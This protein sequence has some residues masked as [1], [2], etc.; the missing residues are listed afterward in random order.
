MA[1]YGQL[2]IDAGGGVVDHGKQS[3]RQDGATVIIGLGGTGT[4]AVI[5][6]KKEIYK[7]LKPDDEN[8]IIPR[9][10]SIRF[11]VVD[12]DVSKLK[13]QNGNQW[14][15]DVNTEF[16]DISNDSIKTVFAAKKV[17]AERKYLD[18][19]DYERISPDDASNGAGGIRQ[20]GRYL[21]FDKAEQLYAKIKSQ[22]LSALTSAKT[23]K[24]NVHICAGISGG[25]GSGTFID[26]CYLV[27]R[28]LEELG[29]ANSQ[30]CG[31]FFLPDVNLSVPS[32][33]ADPLIS[34]YIKVNGY[35]ALQ[36]LDY[37][38]NMGNNKDSF[39]ARYGFTELD[40]NTKPV[41]LCYLVS[42]TD[43]SGKVLDNGYDYAMGVVSDFIINFLARVNLPDGVEQGKDQGLTLEG[44]I[45]NL[46]QMKDGIKL[47]YGASVDYNILGAA[48]AVMPLSEIATYLGSQLFECYQGLYDRAPFEKER[49]EFLFKSQ[50]Q[51]EDIRGV[52][53]KGCAPQ[54]TFGN[55]FDADMYIKMGNKRFIERADEFFNVN[56][57]VL[58]KNA[59]AMAEKLGDFD[60]SQTG[61]SLISRTFKNLYDHYVTN[62][63]FGPFYAKRMIF[64]NNNPNLVHAVDGMIAQNRENTES[65]LRQDPLRKQDLEEAKDRMDGAGMLNKGKRIEEYKAALNNWYVHLYRLEVYN[66][67]DEILQTYRRQ[68]SEL[69][70][71]F[72]NVLT[73]VLDTLRNTFAENA[74]VLSEG[75]RDDNTYTWK[76]LSISDIRAGLDEVIKKTDISQTLYNL[77]ETMFS[78]YKKW[79][80]EDT[81]EITKLISDFIIGQ[82]KEATRKTMTDYLKERFTVDNSALLVSEIKKNII[83]DKLWDKST[84]LFWRN[85]M[86]KSDLGLKTTLTV[87]YD[88]AEIKQAAY[89]FIDG[90]GEVTVRE[91]GIT[92]RLS[93]M[94]FY[95]GLPMY[96]YQGIQELERAYENDHKPG[97]HLYEA[98][99]INWNEMLPSPIPASF[100]IT[101]RSERISKKNERL[102][103]ELEEAKS[104]G[105]V[106]KD[107]LNRTNILITDEVDIDELF[108]ELESI[109]DSKP[110]EIQAFVKKVQD[111]ENS[112]KKVQ[113][114]EEIVIKNYVDDAQET[115]VKD[116]YLL[117]PVLNRMVQNELYKKKKISEIIDLSNARLANGSADT[118]EKQDFFNAIYT[119]IISYGNKIIY[120][121]DEYAKPMELQNSSM[122]FGDTG[123]YCAFRTYK[124]LDDSV[125]KKIV[126]A[127]K[128]RMDEDNSPEVR[129]NIEML[130]SSL[131]KRI[132]GYL[133][134]YEGQLQ[135]DEL[136][137]FYTD[138]MKQYEAFK[139]LH[140]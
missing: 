115:F 117:S 6:L 72:F 66:T 85:S 89:G 21:L 107:E 87:P 56:K 118:K 52:L 112:L 18:W 84:P 62:M 15:I 78:N 123:V 116:F 80:T 12:S 60:I 32:V 25:T 120:S 13:T 110:T 132:A 48:I 93:M 26:V 129:A 108:K 55:Q 103:K 36:E 44:H 88:A 119:G 77:M 100:E 41:D 136:E 96:A 139:L 9:Y 19:L 104:L 57:G 54:V 29:K 65:E 68:L 31:F 91:S 94:R 75:I 71:S 125:K 59:T 121:F 49:D 42:T 46:K 81:N 126:S 30:V 105:I 35:S 33:S 90:H 83:Q 43:S 7:Q 113:R 53:I 61:T 22:M 58:T 74:R 98:G 50:L 128:K 27:K 131:G 45:S 8:A 127:S 14:D 109:Q 11:L 92:D 64:G 3:D 140:M 67:L 137:E 73:T 82:F 130:D 111:I 124:L 95:S 63:E 39:K 1:T 133:T 106:E 2:L 134:I 37:C 69:D 24:L 47:D 23:G 34:G 4:D 76:I 122:E 10:D 51:Y 70:N 97:R 99:P 38:M 79:L 102:L 86:C 138:F 114:K 16:F 17:L 28:A 5:R 135:Y 40:Y 20:V 101:Q